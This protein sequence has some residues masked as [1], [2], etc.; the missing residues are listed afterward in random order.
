MIIEN[1]PDQARCV[2][3]T[4][5]QD[6]DGV[7][8]REEIFGFRLKDEV[9]EMRVGWDGYDPS[10]YDPSSFTASTDAINGNCDRG[11]WEAVT[12]DNLI[13]IE[14]LGFWRD[15][16]QCINAADNSDSDCYVYDPDPTETTVET[17]QIKIR[18]EGSLVNDPSVIAA[19]EQ[20]VRVRND[21]VKEH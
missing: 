3:Y 8:D 2:L 14:N 17:R 13:K 10:T 12:D 7:L 5:D 11:N 15:E 1:T 18:L 4:F 19:I 16:S 9:V 21:R 20:D 6:G